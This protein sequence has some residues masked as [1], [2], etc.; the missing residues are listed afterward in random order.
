MVL[1]C[2]DDDDDD[3]RDLDDAVVVVT[4]V[5]GDAVEVVTTGLVVGMMTGERDE[6]VMDSLDR[7]SGMSL[8][9][10]IGADSQTGESGG[11]GVVDVGL[12]LLLLLLLLLA[13]S[14]F[15]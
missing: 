1:L 6:E 8:G 11:C 9:T 5:S 10:T 12:L 4:E 2:W 15:F 13:M 7:S 14:V 3:M